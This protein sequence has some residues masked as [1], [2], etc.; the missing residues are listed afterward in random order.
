MPWKSAC[1]R[2]RP[3]VD[4]D[5]QHRVAGRRTGCGRKVTKV[6]APTRI[7]GAASPI[8]RAIARMIPVMIPGAAAGSTDRRTI[9]QRDAPKGVGALPLGL[10]DGL[11]RLD[12]GDDDDRQDQQGQGQGA[13][14][15][16][17][18][19]G[20]CSAD[21]EGQPED[22]VDDRRHAG[23]VADVR[24]E[25]AV[26]SAAVAGV[27]GE[28]DRRRDADRE[29][30]AAPTIRPISSEPTS[31]GRMPARAGRRDGTPVR[32]SGSSHGQAAR[33]DVGEEQRRASAS[34]TPIAARH[35]P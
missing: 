12:R 5:R 11:E 32:K 10:G 16:R 29:R 4:L 2:L 25:E 23:Q 3:A 31:A 27:L 8:A 22:A 33:Q 9:C 34:R 17:R 1:G 14:E 6:K 26:V 20:R 28:V 30:D 24:P 21:E 7:S 35:A 15:H 13:G 19:R 18:S